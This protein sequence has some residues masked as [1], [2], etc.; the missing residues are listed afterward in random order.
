MGNIYITIQV[1]L[2]L[3]MYVHSHTHTQ[4]FV[5]TVFPVEELSKSTGFAL[6]NL[7]HLCSTP[8]SVI[9]KQK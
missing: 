9:D 3:Y 8:K 6:K 1:K 5:Y 7:G 4:K 2:C